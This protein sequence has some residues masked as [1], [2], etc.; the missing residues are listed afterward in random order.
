MEMGM[1]DLKLQGFDQSCHDLWNLVKPA[2]EAASTFDQLQTISTVLT[3]N[4][5]LF[6]FLLHLLLSLAARTGYVHKL[7]EKSKMILP[8]TAKEW[9]SLTLLCTFAPP[10]I[11]ILGHCLTNMQIIS[12]NTW[13]QSIF[14]SNL[15]SQ[16]MIVILKWTY[17]FI[18]QRTS[19]LAFFL[20]VLMSL[21]GESG[22]SCRFVWKDWSCIG[23]PYNDFFIIK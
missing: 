6:E 5:F 19:I 13:T 8:S 15:T 12:N 7:L 11:H 3:L 20:F 16:Q 18:P 1:T 14:T 4:L 10:S 17:N 23:G 21:N 9:K 22:S 2:S